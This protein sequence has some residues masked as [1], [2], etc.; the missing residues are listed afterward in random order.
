MFVAKHARRA[1]T[2]LLLLS[3]DDM[4][5]NSSATSLT[6]RDIWKRNGH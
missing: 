6:G 4:V 3:F 1:M 2:S 5:V